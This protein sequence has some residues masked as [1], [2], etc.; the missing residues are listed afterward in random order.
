MYIYN[1][2]LEFLLFA[3]IEFTGTSV[4]PI[5][6]N[7][8]FTCTT[9]NVSYPA[10]Q[11]RNSLSVY[12]EHRGHDKNG[13]SIPLLHLPNED[14]TITSTA[15]IEGR[16]ELNNTIIKCVSYTSCCIAEFDDGFNYPVRVLGQSETMNDN[17]VGYYT[18]CTVLY[19]SL[20]STVTLH[21]RA[22]WGEL[23]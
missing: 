19:W 1:S 17:T 12:P 11:L 7:G 6:Q 18:V 22:L 13:I 21:T 5:G 3:V 9:T 2:L 10:W 23:S 20:G 16:S 4:I 8:M 15:T 14:G